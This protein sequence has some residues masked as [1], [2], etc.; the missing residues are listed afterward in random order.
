M[1]VLT[2]PNCG[3]GLPDGLAVLVDR[4][5]GIDFGQGDFVPAG[6]IGEHCQR[7]GAIRL[8]YGSGGQVADSYR[9]MIVLGQPE[10]GRGQG[11]GR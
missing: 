6:Y 11:E 2:R 8:Q 7:F 1:D 5:A 9:D 4:G 10:D 3:P